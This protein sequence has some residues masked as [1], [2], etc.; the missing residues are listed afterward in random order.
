MPCAI[1]PHALPFRIWFGAEPAFAYHGSSLVASC[2][3]LALR[4]QFSSG[5]LLVRNLIDSVGGRG[6]SRKL[7][8]FRMTLLWHLTWQLCQIELQSK[9]ST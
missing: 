6:D 2:E 1:R 3:P 4:E 9:H 8:K 7:R 5:T